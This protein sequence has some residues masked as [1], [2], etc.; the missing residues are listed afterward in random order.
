MTIA[1]DVDFTLINGDNTPNYDTIDLY[2][3][4]ERNG[5]RMIVWSGG[6]LDYAKMWAEKLHLKPWTCAPKTIEVAR[7]LD[8]DIAVDDEIVALGKV[9]IKVPSPEDKHQ[10]RVHPYDR[11]DAVVSDPTLT[12]T[13]AKSEEKVNKTRIKRGKLD[14]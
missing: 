5:D 3:W 8:V 14:F 11:D 12:L 13:D 2:R 6:G 7:S 1:F 10:V 9:N 4:F